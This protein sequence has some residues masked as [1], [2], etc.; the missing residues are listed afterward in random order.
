L[1]AFLGRLT[2]HF[3]KVSKFSI[4]WEVYVEFPALMAADLH[5]VLNMVNHFFACGVLGQ[6]R[7]VTAVRTECAVVPLD[8]TV[9]FADRGG[10]RLWGGLDWQALVASVRPAAKRPGQPRERLIGMLLV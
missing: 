2:F 3:E 4:T 10:R 9:P 1:T 7:T 8:F 6:I 5:Y